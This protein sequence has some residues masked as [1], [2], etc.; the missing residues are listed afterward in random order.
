MDSSE[1]DVLNKFAALETAG[2][3]NR[4]SLV[5]PLYESSSVDSGMH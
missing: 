1:D 2:T 4:Q 5:S 3:C